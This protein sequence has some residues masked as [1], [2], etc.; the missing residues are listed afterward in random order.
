VK[1]RSVLLTEI[2]RQFDIICSRI[3]SKFSQ[4]ASIFTDP[5]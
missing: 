3:F 1:E 2:H 4:T 5:G